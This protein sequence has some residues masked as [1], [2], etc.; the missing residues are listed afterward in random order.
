M[1]VKEESYEKRDWIN[2]EGVRD[3]PQEIKV[4]SKLNKA[5]CHAITRLF[6]YKRYPHVYKH[7]MYMEFCPHND[8]NRL[9][10][11]YSRFRFVTPGILAISGVR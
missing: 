2:Y 7:R 3:V 8:L 9:I 4:M 10:M 6:N 1:A 11:R 5:K